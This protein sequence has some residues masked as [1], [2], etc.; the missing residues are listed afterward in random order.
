MGVLEDGS[1]RHPYRAVLVALSDELEGPLGQLRL[2]AGFD[3]LVVEVG[4]VLLDVVHKHHSVIE[5]GGFDLPA[6]GVIG[7]LEQRR[8]LYEDPLEPGVPGG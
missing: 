5:G 1:I 2:R 6:D 3:A 7:Q 8:N 4:Q